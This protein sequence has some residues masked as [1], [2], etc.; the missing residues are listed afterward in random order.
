MLRG[1]LCR[2]GWQL[3]DLEKAGDGSFK[4]QYDTPD[5][6]RTVRFQVATIN[7]GLG[8]KQLPIKSHGELGTQPCEFTCTGI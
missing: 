4:L 2:L 7:Q 5:G 6:S 8:V 1:A 3:K